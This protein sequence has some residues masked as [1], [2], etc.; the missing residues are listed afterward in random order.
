MKRISATKVHIT[1]ISQ[2]KVSC[3]K[4]KKKVDEIKTR[5]ETGAFSVHIREKLLLKSL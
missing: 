4:K 3:K 5:L 2:V 1:V